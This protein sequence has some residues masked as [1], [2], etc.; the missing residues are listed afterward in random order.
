MMMPGVRFTN[1]GL[2]AWYGTTDAP[3]PIGDVESGNGLS[4]VVA[5]S[6]A[7]PL[8]RVSVRYSVDGGRY[9]T[10]VADRRP[11]NASGN[12]DYFEALLPFLRPGQSLAYE[13]SV[14]CVGRRASAATAGG[15]TPSLV[16]VREPRQREKEKLPFSLD[17][18]ASLHIPLKEPE[19]I[20]ETPEGIKVNWFWSPAEGDVIGPA[21]TGKVRQIGGD[22]MTVRRDGVALMDVRATIETT[23]G[24]LIYAWYQGYYELGPD[25]YRNFLARRFP[26]RAPTRTTPRFSTSHPAYL[27]LNRTQ[28][29]GIGEVSI[30]KD[31]SYDYDLYAVR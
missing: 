13:P 20:G 25:G 17:Y 5:A 15:R 27:W 18:L 28:C 31:V 21:L 12:I 8:N 7:H 6:P 22:W 24:A 16:T 29:L 4:V 2:T 26:P 3:A 19:S 1:D 30:G 11:S 14:T 10:V 23:D 9:Q